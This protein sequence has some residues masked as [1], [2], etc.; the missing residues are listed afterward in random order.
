MANRKQQSAMDLND[1]QT[2]ISTVSGILEN[3]GPTVLVTNEASSLHIITAWPKIQ[4]VLDNTHIYG[5]K[6]YT[7]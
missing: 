3:N 5:L 6:N 2:I 4:L 7:D 1:L